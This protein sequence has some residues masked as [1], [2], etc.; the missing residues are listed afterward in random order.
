MT[1]EEMV[2]LIQDGQAEYIPQLWDQV[3]LFICWLAK[4]RL[5]GEADYIKQL[6]DDLVN[7]AYFDFL[8]A[9][10]DYKFDQ[11][12]LF[13][14]Y[15][16]YHLKNS[17]SRALGIRSS[18]DKKDLMHKILSLDEPINDTEDLTLQDMI[19]DHMA[20]EYY[21]FAEN[22]DFWRDVR[23]ILEEA[24]NER[25]TGRIREALMVML[26][27]NCKFV[28]ACRLMGI[29]E[30]KIHSMTSMY[31]TALRHIKI[32]LKGR[33]WQRCRQIG[34]DA[35]LSMGLNGSGLGAYRRHGNT[36][37]TERAAIKLADAEVWQR[38]IMEIFG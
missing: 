18:K 4:K 26:E 32:Y 24:I 35:Y 37:S 27:K 9:V 2:K 29:P 16:E 15:L 1:N 13:L 21:R 12:A 33:A 19:I 5:I 10:D 25:T 6:E 20:E 8:M 28:D 31:V 22:N 38:K 30:N 36:S 17:F 34:I 7:E 14:T 3:Y 11:S 23:E